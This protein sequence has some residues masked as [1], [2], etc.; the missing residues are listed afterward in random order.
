[1]SDVLQ[2]GVVGLG[3]MGRNH[4]RVV[5]EVDG[6][7]LA[8]V[9]DPMGDPMG[10]ARGAPVFD[11]PRRLIDHGIDMAVVAAPT[12]DHLDVGMLLCEAGVH[13]LVEKPLADTVESASAII[14]GVRRRLGAGRMWPAMAVAAAKMTARFIGAVG[15]VANGGRRATRGGAGHPAP[16]II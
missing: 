12:S 16:G 1:M 7:E 8:G 14:C 4:A 11:D 13:A 2:V 5:T 3:Q 9:A 6:I 10:A 15:A